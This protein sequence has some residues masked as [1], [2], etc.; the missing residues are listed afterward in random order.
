MDDELTAPLGYRDAVLCGAGATSRVYRAV[1]A[2]TGRVVALKRLHRHMVRSA[3]ALARLRRELRALARL[4]HPALVEVLDVVRWDGAPTVVMD[5]V[6]GEDLKERILRDGPLLFADVERIART[7]LDLLAT[8]HGAGVVHRDVKPQNVRL[9]DDGAIFLLDFGSARMDAASDLT[10]TGTTVGTPEYMAPELF[11]GPV[12]DPRLDIY[13]LGATLFECLTGKPPQAAES[14]A[15]LAYL[16]TTRAIPE[17]ATLRKGTPASLRQLVDRCLARLPDDRYASAS[18]ATW[19]MDHPEH[20]RM[21]RA[22]RSSHPPCLHCHE[23]IDPLTLVCP[24]CGA[25]E[26]FRYTPGRTH[27]EIESVKDPARLLEHIAAQFPERA[28]PASLA[29]LA[30]GC[31]GLSFERQR[32]VS[33]VAPRQAEAIVRELAGVG[34]SATTV[35][36]RPWPALVVLLL[37]LP[38]AAMCSMYAGGNLTLGLLGSLMP[39]GGV[40][41]LLADRLRHFRRARR[42][43]LSSSR[44]PRPAWP[45]VTWLG[46]GLV[47]ASV[48]LCWY[49]PALQL[50]A[51]PR[52]VLD[53]ALGSGVLLFLLSLAF[54]S[55][56]RARDGSPEDSW[57]RQLLAS[58]RGRAADVSASARGPVSRA[59]SLVLLLGIVALV[60]VEIAVLGSLAQDRGGGIRSPFAAAP[61]S[62]LARER[63]GTLRGTIGPD[64]SVSSDQRLRRDPRSAPSPRD[65]R[66]RDD[67]LPWV[68]PGSGAAL[69]RAA[70]VELLPALAALLCAAL[71]ARRALKVRRDR[72]RILAEVDAD[73]LASCRARAVPRRHPALDD[74]LVLPKSSNL[75]SVPARDRFTRAAV[76]RVADLAHCLAIEEVDLL[77]TAL[78]DIEGRPALEAE[79]ALRSRCLMETD[80]GYQA[81]LRFLELEGMLEAEA[82]LRWA[83]D[84]GRASR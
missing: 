6:P 78:R 28:T 25:T 9:R 81:R 55:W 17:V 57:P 12:Y 64:P 73:L 40:A 27:V 61:D 34:V 54:G 74:W 53:V 8:T 4:N 21:F 45:A 13:G 65:R 69:A 37:G 63:A 70:H 79:N 62:A 58:L 30:E 16:R 71:L 29:A 24:H 22:R 68:A 84:A 49:A 44:L 2:A 7:L 83:S 75:S 67:G 82:A 5:Y 36:H 11:A 15:E 76:A 60:P 47:G 20:E 52:T 50:A 41:V 51:S 80:P 39:F 18:L 1:C 3:E 56:R 31:A 77:A 14:I 72:R 10:R 33:F 38:L 46:L 35:D 59:V 23:A 66:L 48:A 42:G 26:P 43:M 19:A 32:Y